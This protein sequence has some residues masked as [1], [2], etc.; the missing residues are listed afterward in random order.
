MRLTLVFMWN[1]A[2]QEMVRQLVYGLSIN[3]NRRSFRL[4]WKQNLV[5]GRK[6]S[7]CYETDSSSNE[8]FSASYGWF[9]SLVKWI[10][11]P[12]RPARGVKQI[13]HI[14]AGRCIFSWY[15]I[16]IIMNM[17]ETSLSFDMPSSAT[18]D[19]K[20]V[21]MV[22]VRLLEIKNWNLALWLLLA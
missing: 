18:F 8:Q 15:K 2:H 22:K 3:N 1:G 16:N 5:K 11:L 14:N 7:K 9:W 13:I 10:N 12:F 19:L 6:T 21:R 17:D 20:A 4:W